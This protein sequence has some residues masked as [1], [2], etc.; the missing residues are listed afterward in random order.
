MTDQRKDVLFP[1]VPL[2][3]ET[4]LP[5]FPH[6]LPHHFSIMAGAYHYEDGVHMDDLNEHK[7][8]FSELKEDRYWAP[9]PKERSV[10]TR[11]AH[12]F[13]R[14]DARAA[15]GISDSVGVPQAGDTSQLHRKLKSRHIQM[16]AI[17]GAIGAG[18]FIG[19]GKALATGGP[20]AVILDFSLVGFMLFCTVNALGELAT[21]YPVQGRTSGEK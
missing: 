14:A 20:G 2:N 12:S 5:A 9:A 21:M 17:G 11:I 1:S 18:L 4:P 19:S 3:I 15:P 8:S 10:L 16:I 6:Y 13:K 7:L